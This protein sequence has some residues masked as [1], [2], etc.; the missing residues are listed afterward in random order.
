MYGTYN[1][2]R[3]NVTISDV[4]IRC[5]TSAGTGQNLNGIVVVGNQQ[6]ALSTATLRYTAPLIAAVSG[7][8]ATTSATIVLSISGSN[9][10]FH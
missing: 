6:S 1:A 9:F 7:N 3:C 5:F 4:E 2:S 10:R 8:L